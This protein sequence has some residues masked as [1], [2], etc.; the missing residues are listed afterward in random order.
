LEVAA[1]FGGRFDVRDIAQYRNMPV[2][3]V[4]AILWPTLQQ[5]DSPLSRIGASR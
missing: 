2:E 5:G 3:E 4:E 1:F